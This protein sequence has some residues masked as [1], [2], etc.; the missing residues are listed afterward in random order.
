MGENHAAAMTI[1]NGVATFRSA[2]IGFNNT[3]SLAMLGGAMTVL[4]NMVVGDCGASV[5]GIVTISGGN[6]YVTNATGD[7]VF[8]IRNRSVTLKC[9]VVEGGQ[10]CDDQRLRLVH[11]HRRHAHLWERGARS[12]PG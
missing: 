12:K 1:S 11:P 8:E 4:S 10:V 6:L 5:T 9:R 7:A 3:G 2:V